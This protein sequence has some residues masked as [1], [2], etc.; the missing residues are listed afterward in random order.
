MVL[1]YI[2]WSSFSMVVS[3]RV[4]NELGTNRPVKACAATNMVLSYAFVLGFIALSFSNSI[5]Y[6]WAKLFTNDPDILRLTSTM[7]PI[8][9]L[10]EGHYQQTTGYGILQGSSWLKLSIIIN[11]GLLYL[12]WMSVALDLSFLHNT[13]FHVLWLGLLALKASGLIIMLYHLIH[14]D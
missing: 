3:T 5:R 10:C 8:L 7:L 9:D 6:N 13:G 1:I 14:T 11:L 12:I 4:G 2:F